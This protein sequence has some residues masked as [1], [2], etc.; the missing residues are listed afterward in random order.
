MSLTE[1][2]LARVM[3][4]ED[5]GEFTVQV[6]TKEGISGERGGG[7]WRREMGGKD[8]IEGG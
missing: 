2:V 8:R 7:V 4:G 6:F 3:R 5:V 1:G